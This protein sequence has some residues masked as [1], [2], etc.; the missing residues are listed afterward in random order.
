MKIAILKTSLLGLF[1][2]VCLT[3]VFA[4]K[5]INEGV[6]NYD[7][8]ILPGSNNAALVKSMEGA[9][10]TVSLKGELSKTEMVSSLGTESDTYDGR[11]GKGFILKEYSGQKLMITLTKDNWL[12]KNQNF[13]H[14]KFNIDNTV[15]TIAGYKCKKATATMTD[16]RIFTLYFSTEYASANKTYNNAFPQLPGIPVQY[17][18]ESGK[19]TFRYA[20]K[21]INYDPVPAAKFEIPKAGYRIM[22]YEE[23]QQLKKGI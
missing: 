2:L 9:S 17:E 20:L 6:L 21:N 16:G 10:L 13:Q 14:L 8:S 11:S 5:A 7:V 18:M 4:Q 23:N 12:N 22:T 1:V 15:Q 19:L 3:G